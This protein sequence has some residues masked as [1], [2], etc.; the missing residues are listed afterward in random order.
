MLSFG[1][2]HSRIAFSC[3]VLKH[4]FRRYDTSLALSPLLEEL[5][6]FR[7]KFKVYPITSGVFFT[8]YKAATKK[9]NKDHIILMYREFT[10]MDLA[11]RDSLEYRTLLECCRG[12]KTITVNCHSLCPEENAL[13]S[14]RWD[15][16]KPGRNNASY[17]GSRVT[18]PR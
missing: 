11:K 8:S 1:G 15:A 17:P 2:G 5:A 18:W 14:C 4:S 10:C 12:A 3:S 7:Y 16:G 13:F 6:V 9:S